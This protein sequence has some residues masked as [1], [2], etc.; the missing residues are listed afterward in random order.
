MWQSAS[1]AA[2]HPWWYVSNMIK[3]T[4]AQA[5]EWMS[6]W[7]AAGPALARVRAEPDSHA[8]GLVEQQRLFA[9]ARRR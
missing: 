8:S 4:D 7:R 2:G 1:A 6:Q 9:A 3:P 5:H